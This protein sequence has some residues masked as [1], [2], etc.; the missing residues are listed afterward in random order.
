MRAI[1]KAMQVV[2]LAGGVGSRLRPWTRSIPKPLLPMLDLTLLERV[3]EAIPTEMIDEIIV[4]GGY[5]VDMIESYFQSKDVDFDVRIVPEDEPLGTGGALGNCRDVV[6]GTFACFNGDIVSSLKIEPMLELHR[7][8]GGVGTLALWEV[9]DPTRFGIVGVDDEHKI[10]RFMEKPK[11]EQVFSN[12]INAGSYI[13][14]DDV[15]DWMPRG[16]HSIERDVFPKLAEANFLNGQQFEGYFI[17]AGTPTAWMEGVQRCIRE[18]RFN[19]G[20]AVDGTWY[21]KQNSFPSARIEGSMIEAD[22]EIGQ[23]TIN[24]STLLAHAKVGLNARVSNSLVGRSATIGENVI[25]DGVVV[26]HGST[27]PNGTVQQGG[28]WPKVDTAA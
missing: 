6:S 8:N 24:C 4:A 11:P 13:F 14:E 10:Q 18:E 21:A 23:A 28:Q 26:D 20:R 1:G 5:K 16:R 2:V 3:V 9:E 22:V 7:T 15:F 19:T 25:L 27:I 17:D 12:L